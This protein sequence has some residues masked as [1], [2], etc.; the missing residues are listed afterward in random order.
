M[1]AIDRLEAEPIAGTEDSD[2][3]FFSSD[4]QWV[5]FWKGGELKK[6]PAGGGPAVTICETAPVSGAS[7][8]S[9]NLVVFARGGGGLW[10][11]SGDGGT[12]QP[13]TTLDAN[14]GE[15][16][17]VLPH[18]LPG[19]KAVLFTIRKAAGTRPTAWDD[20]Q[21]VVRSLVSGDQTT[22][23]E[24]GADARYVS[25]GHLVYVRQG[26]LMAVPFDLD[27]L[28]LTGAAVG[29]VNSVMQAVNT[30]SGAIET[31]AAQFS[32]SASGTLV[33]VS[34][35][36][37]PEGERSLIWVDRAGVIQLLPA[38]PKPYLGPRLSPDG[39]R[40]AVFTQGR[41]AEVWIYDL[42]RED[43]T[44]FTT[45][46]PR[47]GT[48]PV[49]TPD[50]KRLTFGAGN[51][52]WKPADGSGVAEPL[53]TSED[54]QLPESWSPDGKTLA[55]FQGGTLGRGDIWMLSLADSDRTARPFVQTAAN[56]RW[57]DFSPDGR[58]LAYAS[59][60]SGR[61]EVYVQ[62][63]PGPGSRHQISARG[64][65]QPVWAR[66]GRELF[67]TVPDST[68]TVDFSRMMV[69]DVTTAPTFTAGIPKPLESVVRLTN[70]IRGYDVT[71]D[72]KRFITVRDNE[73]S[74]EPP[75]AHMIVVQN[76]LEELKL[77]VP[78]K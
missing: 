9:N 43:L 19:G 23:I 35:G 20:A 2:S 72:G 25:T 26:T 1:R 28:A 71:A 76:W 48:R 29:I 56:E 68:A 65:T 58:W 33:Y 69:V 60:E 27:R 18:V 14:N 3:P 78:T 4:G 66:N 63:Y 74:P 53:T 36:M 77:L 38:P 55:F 6:V 10:Q 47:R 67:Y 59:D 39:Q 11:V 61:D 73:R 8:G 37:F 49:W 5:G 21:I 41:D 75:P 70:P 34:G 57:P 45:T 16:N 17:H 50:G 7:W 40:V 42:V 31:G 46:R 30:P 52:L 12:P 13:L 54:V 51:L 15:R 24:G 22:L 62:P 64:G 44:M 32:V